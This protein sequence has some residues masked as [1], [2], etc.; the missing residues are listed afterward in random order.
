[1]TKAF[2]VRIKAPDTNLYQQCWSGNG[3]ISSISISQP[4]VKQQDNRPILVIAKT[5]DEAAAKYKNAHEIVELDVQNI[6][7][8]EKVDI[9][10]EKR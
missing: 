3:G 1:M 7:I 2:L 10:F 4:F 6:I 9:I 5:I 8:D